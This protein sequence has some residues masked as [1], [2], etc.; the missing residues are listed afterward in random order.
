MRKI[1]KKSEREI[2]NIEYEE[3]KNKI[4]KEHIK[5]E[6][7]D[8]IAADIKNK[9]Q[10]DPYVKDLWNAISFEYKY[11]LSPVFIVKYW[12]YLDLESVGK[13]IRKYLDEKYFNSTWDRIDKELYAEI[14]EEGYLKLISIM[15]ED[16]K[17]STIKSIFDQLSQNFFYS[18]ENIHF[19]TNFIEYCRPYLGKDFFEQISSFKNLSKEFIEENIEKM[20]ERTLFSNYKFDDDF[21][22]KIKDKI[23]TEGMK[24][25]FE[26]QKIKS[27]TIEE[28]SEDFTDE[29]FGIVTMDQ[30]LSEDFI[31]KNIDKLDPHLI[32]KYQPITDEIMNMLIEKNGE[33][34]IYLVHENDKSNLSEEFIKN[35]EETIGLRNILVYQ[36]ISEEYFM[37]IYNRLEEKRKNSNF[38]LDLFYHKNLSEKILQYLIETEDDIF[39]DYRVKA[40]MLNTQ[41][42]SEDFLIKNE[43]II[44][45]ASIFSESNIKNLSNEF[46]IEHKDKI[47]FDNWIGWRA[48]SGAKILKKLNEEV[49]WGIRDKLT[50]KHWDIISDHNKLSAKF[51]IGDGFHNINLMLLK[52]N[53][54][55]D[56][57]EM[58]KYKVFEMLSKGRKED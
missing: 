47:D 32:I 56:M 23:S 55:I 8:K 16:D 37:D 10:N 13:K 44:G 9:D 35:H 29:M 53:E 54:N 22:L 24:V 27:E 33:K 48:R 36:N 58:K 51:I 57:D 28:L 3:L 46:I 50:E 38:Y 18:Y 52:R 7:M 15:P 17:K 45:W 42:I 25:L 21:I 30:R 20:D 34:I 26:K 19:S 11:D 49:I 4:R 39:E 12:D 41:N 2:D 1:I 14:G 43:D 5:D 31:K 6:E 40:E